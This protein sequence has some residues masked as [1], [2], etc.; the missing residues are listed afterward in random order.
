MELKPPSA[1]TDGVTSEVSGKKRALFMNSF[2]DSSVGVDE[3]EL[4]VL[5]LWSPLSLSGSLRLPLHEEQSDR[6]IFLLRLPR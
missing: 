4:E 2:L 5:D 6:D 3:F 1:R